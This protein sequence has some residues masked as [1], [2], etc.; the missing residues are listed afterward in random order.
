MRV[1]KNIYFTDRN[2]CDTIVR[3][4]KKE[5]RLRGGGLPGV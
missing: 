4:I 3:I 2:V 5:T 1:T